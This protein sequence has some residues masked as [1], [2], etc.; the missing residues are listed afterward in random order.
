MGVRPSE[1]LYPNADLNF[2]F[3]IDEII[4]DVGMRELAAAQKRA[5]NRHRQR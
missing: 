5:R 1:R 4:S 3:A 2:R